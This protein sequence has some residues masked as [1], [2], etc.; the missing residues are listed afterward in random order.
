MGFNRWQPN[1][2][3]LVGRLTPGADGLLVQGM[4]FTL[5]EAWLELDG[6][7]GRRPNFDHS[8]LEV[9][10]ELPDISAIASLPAEATLPAVPLALSGTLRP[11]RG[12]VGLEQWVMVSGQ[13]R[14][15]LSGYLAFPVSP[16]GR[17]P[18]A[19]FERIVGSHVQ[20]SARL[21]D[22]RAVAEHIGLHGLPARRLELVANLKLA[23]RG[24]EFEITHGALGDLEALATGAI[25]QLTSLDGA[26]IDLDLRLPSLA[27]IEALDEK[28]TLPDLPA[29]IGGTIGVSGSAL[30]LESLEGGVGSSTFQLDG[31]LETDPTPYFRRARFSASGPD[32]RELYDHGLLDKVPGRFEVS[33]AF[34]ASGER[35]EIESFEIKVGRT[36]V[37]ISGAMETGEERAFDVNAMLDAPEPLQFST[38]LE[39]IGDLKF[40]SDPLTIRSAVQA[41]GKRFEFRDIQL[42]WG[43]TDLRGTLS[44]EQDDIPKY[45]GSFQSRYLDLG[46]LP[47]AGAGKDAGDAGSGGNERRQGQIFSDAPLPI[48]DRPPVRV[49]LLVTADAGALGHSRFRDTRLGLSLEEDRVQLDPIRVTGVGGGQFEGAFSLQRHGEKFKASL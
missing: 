21:E 25:P 3:R 5:G 32:F 43:E 42:A 27:S 16:D 48:T 40:P 7:L 14:V 47:F 4:K 2:Y 17:S 46:W 31:E 45:D 33:G 30:R 12:G 6:R 44:V 35:R 49:N 8:D 22:A 13:D 26:R 41:S 36:T 19:W 1:P 29:H 18:G 28:A 10:L 20:A 37:Q 39:K 23:E 34:T 11:R 38:L 24:L 9:R 15:E